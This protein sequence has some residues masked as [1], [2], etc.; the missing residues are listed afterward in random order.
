MT[1][2]LTRPSPDIDRTAE[3]LRARGIAVLL[4][5][6]LRFEPVPLPASVGD[7]YGA[8]IVTSANALRA[9]APQLANSPLKRLPLFVVGAQTASIARDLGFGKVI[10]ADGDAVALRELIAG[11]VKKRIFKKR[12]TLLYLAAADVSRD[13][14]GELTALG[15]AVT[16]QTVY[17]MAEVATL[18]REV[19]A[20]FAAHGIE[21]VLHY[22]RRSAA[23][24]VAAARE[25]GVEI[26]ALAV[27]QC[28]MSA[29]VAEVL[30]E[31]GASQI[32]IAAQL[33]EDEL[34][35]ALATWL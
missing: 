13:L 16:T 17:R 7:D 2:L 24:F 21:A 33:N 14:A 25:G 29:S 11:G 22:S 19:C 12:D 10:S 1:V 35:E 32:T 28:C 34:L 9:V 3:T 20:A 26:S 18:P 27:P 23:A 4:A 15:F 5:P 6:M 31:A 8:L 30:R